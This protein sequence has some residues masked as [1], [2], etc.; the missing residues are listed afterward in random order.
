MTNDDSEVAEL[1]G[2]PT[3]QISIRY[4]SVDLIK[5]PTEKL[6][7]SN[8]TMS[9]PVEIVLLILEMA[10]E[11]EPRM[12]RLG[13]HHN[14]SL[15]III[16]SNSPAQ[17]YVT[18][19]LREMLLTSKSLISKLLI[20]REEVILTYEPYF[21]LPKSNFSAGIDTLHISTQL[22]TMLRT[23][24]PWRHNFR[25]MFEHVKYLAL[26]HTPTNQTQE[27]P[28]WGRLCWGLI[29]SEKWESYVTGADSACR[30]EA[31]ALV[32]SE[33]SGY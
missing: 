1:S 20:P 10:V 11:L 29:I 15:K 5:S 24:V 16:L 18:W 4:S 7:T 33:W 3:T 28:F 13:C 21:R 14:K 9:L 19:E 27:V 26:D 32:M 6:G 22:Y 12:I 2:A 25:Q 8:K 23:E 17:F 31:P 30:I